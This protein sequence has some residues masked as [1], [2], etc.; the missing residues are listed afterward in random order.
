MNR[1]LNALLPAALLLLVF[2]LSSALIVA[3]WLM[4]A[5]CL[6]G[7]SR[8][9]LPMGL[10]G[11]VLCSIGSSL[12]AQPVPTGGYIVIYERAAPSPA[13]PLPPTQPVADSTQRTQPVISK[14]RRRTINSVPTWPAEPLAEENASTPADKPTFLFIPQVKPGSTETRGFYGIRIRP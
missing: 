8:F 6:S 3:A 5:F 10:F 13:T 2:A 4:I 12:H 7:I 9:A 1:L 14:G 11:V